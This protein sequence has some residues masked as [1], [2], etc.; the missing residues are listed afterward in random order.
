MTGSHNLEQILRSAAVQFERN[1]TVVAHRILDCHS[2]LGECILYDDISNQILWTDILGKTFN[3]LNLENGRHESYPLSKILGAF[4]MLSDC[5]LGSNAYLFAW[6]DGFQ[7]FDVKK[8]LPLSPLSEGE[9]VN[10]IKLPSRL[11]DGRVDR[12]G[13]RF[14][15]GGFYGDIPGNYMKVFQVELDKKDTLT[16]KHSAIIEKI[17]VTNSIC[18]SPDGG[19][20]YLADSPT[21]VIRRFQYNQSDGTLSNEE[22]FRKLQVGVPDGSCVDVEGNLWNAVWR[23]GVGRSV[24]QCTDSRTK[25][26]IY[27]VQMPDEIS[28]I[29]CV[30]FGGPDLDVLFISTAHINLDRS[31][32]PHAGCLYA[33]KVGIKGLV[34][35]RFI[36]KH[37]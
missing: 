8:G 2:T 19:T 15:C 18:W 17:Q 22:V 3:S 9:D 10:P 29:T 26:V 30:C 5:D 16:L 23:N 37:K 1:G 7:I 14:I 28:Q 31:K 25:E 12:T 24:V 4:G 20:L 21:Q 27:T 34:E 6:E 11:N 36:L 35:D 13:R 33:V 32:E